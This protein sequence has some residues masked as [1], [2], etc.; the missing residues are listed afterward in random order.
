VPIITVAELEAYLQQDLSDYATEAGDAVA[1]A[2]GA[3]EEH[4]RRQFGLVV[5][6][7]LTMR[8]RPSIVLPN[9][10]VVTVTSFQVDG[11]DSDYSIDESGRY[12]PRSTGEQISVTYTHGYDSIP[13]T[14]RLVA[15]RLAARIFKNPVGRVSY[16][17]DNA[18]MQM[19]QDVSPRVLTGD[20]MASLVK[21]RLRRS[22]Q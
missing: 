5:D 19:S 21:Y 6:D 8:W 14:P 11:V 4:C 18:S 3:V 12:W 2:S 13:E 15:K 16:S 10:P 1:A 9:P 7:E 17:V 20:E 22:S